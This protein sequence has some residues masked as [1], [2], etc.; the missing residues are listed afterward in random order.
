MKLVETL[1]DYLS[2]NNRLVCNEP[3]SFQPIIEYLSGFENLKV[4]EL[5]DSIPDPNA[6][7]ELIEK[8]VVRSSTITPIS[9]KGTKTQN[10]FH[11]MLNL[12]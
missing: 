12:H 4:S 10:F 2:E 5:K 9:H 7:I 1:P 11:R 6:S 8:H 3:R